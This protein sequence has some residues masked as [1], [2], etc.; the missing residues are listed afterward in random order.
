[1]Y[2]IKVKYDRN[3]DKL[4]N[5]VQKL[6]DDMMNLTRPVLSV[7]DTEWSPEA[8]MYETE[9]EIFLVVN[10]AGVKREDIEVSF[11]ENYICIRGERTHNMP[12]G[13][14][15]RYH[16]LEMGYG[17]FERVFRVPAVADEN[18]IEASYS[19]GILTICMRKCDRSAQVCVRITS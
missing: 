12:S 8:D 11:H 4:H 16:Q 15:V 18:E 6:M 17:N 13:M 2:L 5:R 14:L 3:L 1:M 19:D 10:L 7:H 9:H